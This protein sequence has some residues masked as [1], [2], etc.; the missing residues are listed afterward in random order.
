MTSAALR[1]DLLI[2]Q[3]WFTAV[4]HPAQSTTFT[5]RVLGPSDKHAFLLSKE[6]EGGPWEDAAAE[7]AA[8]APTE[9]FVVPD[10]SLRKGTLRA[11]KTIAADLATSPRRLL[12]LDGHL[13]LLAAAWP[14]V[15]ARLRA[16]ERVAILYLAGPERIAGNKLAAAIVRR[17]VRRPEARLFLRTE[18]LAQSWREFLPGCATHIGVLPSLELHD[19]RPPQAPREAPRLRF[20]VFGQVRPGKSLEW[21][22]PL[23]RDHPEAGGLT[24]AGTFNAPAHRAALE[25]LRG[26]DGFVDRYLAEDELLAR[27]AEQDYVVILYDQW[28]SRME[29]ANLFLAARAGRPVIAYDAGWCGRNVREYG[30]GA[31][32]PPGVRPT[33]EWFRALPRPGDE[34]YAALLAGMEAF[35]VAHSGPAVRRRFLD[36]LMVD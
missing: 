3:P 17:F 34:R 35:R 36:A 12:F 8:L 4:G 5:A 19:V 13:V 15:R 28:D 29:A 1:C 31:L 18:E 7:I 11:L 32:V 6:P 26:F 16:V 25:V 21:L 30:C 24:V 9:R 23:F 22:V 20:G 10:A 33:H 27:A 14:F 2:V